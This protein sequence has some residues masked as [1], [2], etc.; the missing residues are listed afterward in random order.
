[1]SS[2]YKTRE[3]FEAERTILAVKKTQD[4]TKDQAMAL[5]DLVK[6]S[7]DVGQKINVYA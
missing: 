2:S 5:L 7:S 1:V 6:Q 3:T 4:A